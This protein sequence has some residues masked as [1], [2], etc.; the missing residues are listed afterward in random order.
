MRRVKQGHLGAGKGRSIGGPGPGGATLARSKMGRCYL[1]VQ[2][3][4]VS[5]YQLHG[6]KLAFLSCLCV[7][8]RQLRNP[9]GNA[10]D[11][12]LDGPLA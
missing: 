9:R 3:Q 10:E 8:Q 1:Q 4:Y 12:E 7:S 5:G 11:K 2:R 6:E